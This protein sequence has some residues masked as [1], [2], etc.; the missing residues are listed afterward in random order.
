MKRENSFQWCS[1]CKENSAIVK[2]YD[3]TDGQR[4]RVI[5]CT[6]KGCGYRQDLPFPEEVVANVRNT[7]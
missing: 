4:K 3:G 1:G 2:C 6:N 5:Y 7:R